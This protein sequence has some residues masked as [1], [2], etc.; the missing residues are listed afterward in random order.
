MILSILFM[1][2]ITFGI[3]LP[4]IL[5]IAPKADFL[6]KLGVSYPLGIGVFAFLMFG[7][8]LLGLKFTLLN[9]LLLLLVVS[10]P[11]ILTQLKKIKSLFKDIKENIK[12]TKFDLAEK[13]I[14]GILAFLI[15]TSFIS[16]FYWPVHMW[17]SVVLYDFRGHVFAS[18]GFMKEA[19]MNA[20]YYSY[21]LLTSLAHAIVY[22]CGGKYPQFIYSIFYL[23][24]GISFYGLIKEFVSR[25]V[26]L[27]ATLLLLMTGPL[28]YHS[29]YS[30][31]NLTYTVYLSL[32]AILIYLWSRKWDIGYLILSV[33]L[34]GFSIH[35]RATEP[36]WLAAILLVLVVSIIKKRYI[37]I[38]VYLLIILPMRQIWV[39]Y[40]QVISTGM[41]VNITN[42]IGISST[43]PELANFSR[44]SEVLDF[45]Y[46]YLI[47]PQWPL[48]ALF[49]LSGVVLMLKK[50]K[51][52]LL[53][54]VITILFVA[55][56]IAGTFIF[57][58]YLDYWNRIGDA[59]E[60]LSMIFYP[61]LVYSSALLLY[62]LGRKQ[63]Q[64]D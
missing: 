14:L 32:G 41:V 64:Y 30:Y 8:N 10:V 26:S 56:L 42:K 48:F 40:Q 25:K 24:L 9:E 58:I 23:S 2:L 33:L 59:T 43:L 7:T 3:G 61:L 46:K 16:T 20:Y 5:F 19:F 36:F 29:L 31:T 37:G 13:I 62:D 44:W 17:D 18:T 6:I 55:V 52:Q 4:L 47:I 34:I 21:P 15:V 53:M 27:F 54:F 22:L 57:S 28:F 39:S 60:R 49:F 63:K 11:L 38:F 45:L 12:S 50:Q 35:I 51:E 1:L